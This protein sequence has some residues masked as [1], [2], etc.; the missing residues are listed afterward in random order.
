MLK[1]LDL[2]WRSAALIFFAPFAACLRASR[3]KLLTALSHDDSRRRVPRTPLL[4]SMRMQSRNAR[5][6]GS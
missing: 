4:F 6:T 5:K 2:E 3:F 1:K